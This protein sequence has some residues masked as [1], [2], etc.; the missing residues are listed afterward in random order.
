MII[1]K[2]FGHKWIYSKTSM[3]TLRYYRNCK[4]CAAIAEYREN[5]P[6]YGSGWFQLV[7]FTKQG[8]KDLLIK[9]ERRNK[10]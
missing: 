2:L 6:A 9:L 7:Q 1:C 10:T 8:A 4:R 5:V 3:G